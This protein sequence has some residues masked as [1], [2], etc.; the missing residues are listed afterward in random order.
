MNAPT[1][2]RAQA[3]AARQYSAG[4]AIDG[5]SLHEAAGKICETSAAAIDKLKQAIAPP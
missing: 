2:P 1:D 3:E 4:S 5:A